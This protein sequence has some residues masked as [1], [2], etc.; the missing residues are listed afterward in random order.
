MKKI[1][2]L[3]LCM[4]LMPMF[5]EHTS[6]TPDISNANA[7]INMDPSPQHVDTDGRAFGDIL[8][9]IDL[10]SAGMPGDGYDN[11]GITWDGQYVYLI[12][13]YDNNVYV[14][15]PITSL[16]V[17]NFAAAPSLSW[18][19]GHE[20]LLWMTEYNSLT[21]YEYTWAGS[22]TGSSFPC[23]QGGAS[24]MGDMS[25]WWQDGEIWILAVG[26][27]NKSYKFTV[28]GGTCI[29]S[30]S[31]PAWTSISQRGFTYDPFNDKFFVG[32]WNSDMVWELN[33]DG[34]VTGR[35]FAFDNIASLA[36]DW[37]S[38]IHPTPVIWLATNTP[39][40][41]LYMIDADNP[42]PQTFP[43][44]FEDG[45]QGWTHTNG[46]PFP[47][48][49]S[50]E[51]YDY[52][53]AWA[54][55]SPGDS[56]F[57][58]DSDAS[59]GVIQDTAWSPVVV[60]PTNMA[61]LVYGY[62]FHSY[63]GNDWTAVGVRTFSG[64]GWNAPVEL[65]RYTVDTYGSWDTLDVSAYAADDSIRVFFYYDGDYDWWSAFDNVGLYAP[66]EHDVGT[67]AINAPPTTIMPSTTINPSATYHN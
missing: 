18:G 56:S 42:A 58:V 16:V 32:G 30:I 65:T 50:V 6:D 5:A 19:C 26:G 14:I 28:P 63:S 15:D 39:T 66:P 51:A 12:S 57:W 41:T 40:N 8:L 24:W 34:S 49:W 54:C 55:P 9:T 59:G 3:V 44:D 2:I 67:I 10:T 36:Y 13:M 64:G 43:W 38:T 60:P 46:Q 25:E 17:G 7:R 22:A 52:Q 27:S 21:A 1:F 62:S 35:Q 29:D 33:N 23:L 37:Q 53:S 47:A 48:G 20:Q 61:W 4:G 45:W 11:A 31:D